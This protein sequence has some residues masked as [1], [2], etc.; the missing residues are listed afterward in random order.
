MGYAF[1]VLICAL[2]IL[3]LG[4]PTSEVPASQNSPESEWDR[5]ARAIKRLPPSSFKHLPGSIVRKLESQGC[6]IPQAVEIPKP[7]NAISGEFARKGQ[8]DWAV[9]CSRQG[10][11][12]L[13]IFWG[14]GTPCPSELAASED[15]YWLQGMG[16]DEIGYSRAIDT[17]GKKYI[18]AHYEA[19]GGAKPPPIHHQGIDDGFMGK[20]SVVYYCH[21][22]EWLQLQGAD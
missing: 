4:L 20:F 5:A 11:T 12:S 19:Y 9:L 18:I 22:G 17:V 10:Q 14:K 6:T 7:H 8:K 3:P 16:N 2:A 13:Q 15:R 1:R 21:Q